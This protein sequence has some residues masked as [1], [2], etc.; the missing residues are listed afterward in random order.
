MS[1]T[2]CPCCSSSPLTSSY[3]AMQSG[4]TGV[5]A[6]T[7]VAKRPTRKVPGSRPAAARKEAPRGSGGAGWGSS[8][9]APAIT[10]RRA[11]ASCT[12]RAIGPLTPNSPTASPQGPLETRPRDGLSPTSPHTLDGMRIEPPPSDPCAADANPAATAAAAPPLDPPA[13]RDRS[14]GVRAGGATSFS[15]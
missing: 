6:M 8:T 4:C 10:S 5:S 9:K 13:E 14:H 11:A 1:S 12:V 15:V 7:G 3:A 2:M